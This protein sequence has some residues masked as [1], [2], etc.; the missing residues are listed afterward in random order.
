VRW[1]VWVVACLACSRA[2]A[3]EDLAIPWKPPPDPTW[4]ALPQ[5]D[6]EARALTDREAVPNKLK[7]FDVS[8]LLALRA[9]AT[10]LVAGEAQIA[11]AYDAWMNGDASKPSYL[12]F[13]TL[14]DSRAQIETVA[15]IVFRMK[16]PWGFALEQFRARGKWKDAPDT[17]SADDA[18]LA[19]LTRAHAALDEGAMWRVTARQND[20]DH[21]AWKFGY[22]T[23]VANLIYAAR[24]ASMPL[25]ACD[26]P[27][28]LRKNFTA[29][30]AA[31]SALRELHC[32]RAL[33]GA[34]IALAPAHP[35]T[36][37]GLTDDDAMPPERY[38]ILVGANH[39]EPSG[40]PRFL[41]TKTNAARVVSV[42]VLGGRPRDA[43]GEETALASRL[44]VMDPVLVRGEHGAPDVLLLPDD[45]W[46]GTID[47]AIDRGDHDAPPAPAAGLPRHDVVVSSDE[48]ARFAIGDASVDVAK[49]TESLS[50]RA[51][52]QPF[53]L[54]TKTRTI[55]GAIDVPEIGFAEAR[56][57]PTARELRVVVHAP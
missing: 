38:A 25:V 55:V 20:L 42:R 40:L 7:P 47:R 37:A 53:V 5:N 21:A 56:F 51:G 33:H 15:S 44:V 26:L 2:S 14:H 39:A 32:A 19:T 1:V 12:I 11:S 8:E 54:T 36:D 6:D 24:G 4:E 10:R 52:H 27:P 31:E 43:G 23:S 48:P 50:V 46:S 16:A 41:G 57:S 45:A 28:E 13:G 34:A 29:G 35:P 49:T 9:D 3:D 30:G 22:V 18:D 17:P